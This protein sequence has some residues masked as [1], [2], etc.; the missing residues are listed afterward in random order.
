MALDLTVLFVHHVQRQQ[1]Q[2]S[3]YTTEQKDARVQIMD[4]QEKKLEAD[5]LNAGLEKDREPLEAQIGSVKQEFEDLIKE[6][7]QMKD[8]FDSDD[9]EAMSDLNDV[10]DKIN[11]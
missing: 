1:Q 2:V 8:D 11:A 3:E 9:M 4:L 10:L 6:F 7:H 5:L